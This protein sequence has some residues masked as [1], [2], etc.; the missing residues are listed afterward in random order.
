MSMNGK[1]CHTSTYRN[2]WVRIQLKTGEW[3]YDRFVQSHG[4]CVEL[5]YRGK[6]TKGEVAR[7]LPFIGGMR[8]EAAEYVRKAYGVE[9]P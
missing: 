6:I 4:S 5:M 1:Q 8:H 2:K 9:K 7:F 3:L